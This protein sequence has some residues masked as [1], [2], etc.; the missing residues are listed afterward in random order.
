MRMARLSV[1]DVQWSLRHGVSVIQSPSRGLA[2]APTVRP[3][4][5]TGET[6]ASKL[7]A[8]AATSAAVCQ[9][10]GCSLVATHEVLVCRA[11]SP[12]CLNHAAGMTAATRL[13]GAEAKLGLRYSR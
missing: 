13:I 12:V 4:A 1:H 2:K 9:F 5:D 6:V 8:A 10:P 7:T 11:W 3:V